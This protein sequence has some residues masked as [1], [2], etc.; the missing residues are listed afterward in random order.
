MKGDKLQIYVDKTRNHQQQQKKEE[1][2][3]AQ[4]EEK[5]FPNSRNKK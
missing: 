1:N 3:K 5:F 4:Q 2:E